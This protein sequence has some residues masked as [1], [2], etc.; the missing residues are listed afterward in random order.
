MSHHRQH[1]LIDDDG[2]VILIED[3]LDDNRA[4]QLFDRLSASCPWRQD[5]LTLFGRKV[6]AP[7]LSCW[8]GDMPYTYS[9]L[10]LAPRPW[11]PVLLDMREKVEEV[12]GARFNSVLL[13]LY[14]DGR[15]S[16]GWHSDDEPEL[17]KNPVIASISLG[18][19]RR[20]R[21]R[22]KTQKENTVSIDLP[23]ASLLLM[24]GPTQH[25]WQHALPKTSRMIGPRLNLTF[26]WTY[27][28]ER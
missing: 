24:S 14:R 19:V 9:G 2:H 18:E 8:Y 26:R 3:L 5:V 15:D 4:L 20:F 23:H 1:H 11:S 12:T 25:H 10:T 13:N 6:P 16:M 17:G 28:K 22:H 21:L 7:R 27:T